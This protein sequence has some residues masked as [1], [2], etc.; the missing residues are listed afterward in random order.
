[1][2]LRLCLAFLLLASPALAQNGAQDAAPDAAR[3]KKA[4]F[5]N[6]WKHWTPAPEQKPADYAAAVSERYGLSP[7]PYDNAELPMGLRPG[8]TPLGFAGIANDCMLCHASSL[9]G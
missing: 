7:A 6:V 9:L 8:K 3:G 5:E 1:M 4:S 2:R